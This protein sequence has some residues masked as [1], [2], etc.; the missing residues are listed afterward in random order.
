M[1]NPINCEIEQHHFSC[2][3]ISI[4]KKLCAAVECFIPQ[5]VAALN[6][7]FQLSF[8][9]CQNLRVWMWKTDKNMFQFSTWD[10]T[11]RY[12]FTITSQ[13]KNKPKKVWMHFVF[14][15]WKNLL[16]WKNVMIIMELILKPVN[17]EFRFCRCKKTRS[18]TKMSLR[19]T[20]FLNL[21]HRQY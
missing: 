1:C 15:S 14:E 9:N 2:L 4:R 17:V 10:K 5:S 3:V 11:S 8:I 21:S 6:Q 20:N 12:E 7:H 13:L 19:I 16:D 18:F